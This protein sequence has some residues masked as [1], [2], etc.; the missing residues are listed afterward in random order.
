MPHP[1]GALAERG[2]RRS[3]RKSFTSTIR[4]FRSISHASTSP[5]STSADS[6]RRSRHCRANTDNSISAMFSH[7]P[8]FGV[9]WTSSF[10][11]IRLARSGRNHYSQ[12]IS[13]GSRASEHRENGLWDEPDMGLS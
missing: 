13:V 10:S 2:R 3:T 6:I 4:S 1:T 5:T 9:W 8:C 12:E 11:A 7:H